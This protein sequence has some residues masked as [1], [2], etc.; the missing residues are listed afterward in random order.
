MTRFAARAFGLLSVLLAVQVAGLNAQVRVVPNDREAFLRRALETA[1]RFADP[2]AAIRA[3]FR[4]LG[5]EFPGMG[6]HWVHPGRIV[7]GRIDASSPPVLTYARRNDGK[8]ALLGLAWA[9]PL[10]SGQAP[11]AEP[12][13]SDAWHD[14]TGAVD[15]E[16]L[17]LGHVPDEPDAEY[18]FRLSMVHVWTG[19]ENPDGILAQNNWALPFWRNGLAVPNRVS[20]S[21]ARAL[22]LARDGREFY[23]ALLERAVELAAEERAPVN[24]VLD[25]HAARIEALIERQ[26]AR[27]DVVIDDYEVVWY[28]MWRAVRELVSAEQWD[29]L[30]RF[31]E[32]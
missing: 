2:S 19:L 1:T 21:A 12:F 24:R 13:G 9:V 15:E 4:C 25:A 11:P 23:R 30:S 17:L 3:G 28:D 7:S 32:A 20:R 29:V 8:L 26:R 31:V 27:S 14:H 10:A 6:Q 22:S 5:P 16:I 18:R